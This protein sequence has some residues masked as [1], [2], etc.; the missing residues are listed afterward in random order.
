M[1]GVTVDARDASVAPAPLALAP[2]RPSLHVVVRD[3]DAD[4]VVH[5]LASHVNVLSSRDPWPLLIVVTVVDASQ[6]VPAVTP[7]ACVALAVLALQPKVL[8]LQ[9]KV[10]KLQPK[11][12]T[13]QPKVNK[14]QPK[15]NKLQPKVN[16]PRARVTLRNPEQ[17]HRP[18]CYKSIDMQILQF[19][20]LWSSRK[21]LNQGANPPV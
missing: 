12:R 5:V 6:D 4:Q 2:K 1:P 14:L 11:V 19:D 3:V 20:F 10:N 18:I 13:L 16:K 8:T 15:V 7:I 21:N 17:F 9:P